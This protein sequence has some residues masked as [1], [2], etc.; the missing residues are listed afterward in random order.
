MERILD[1]QN[2][3]TIGAV[4]L[5][6]V[7][8]FIYHMS[9]NSAP[10]KSLNPDQWILFELIDKISL[11]HDVRRFRFALPSKDHVVGLPIGQHIS[12]KFTDAEG[13]AVIRS[14]TPTTNDKDDKGYFEFCVKIYSPAPPK[15]PLGG[16][17]SQH[18]DSLKIGDKVLMKG[19][20]GHV[21]YKGRGHFTIQ[22]KAS[23][24]SHTVKTIGM[25]AGGTGT[26]PF[27]CLCYSRSV[28]SNLLCQASHL[29]CS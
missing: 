6:L 27:D 7:A 5:V 8:L 4:V 3:S 13:K 2:Y 10:K 25:I 15:F 26:R 16:K 22:R 9:A 20:K 11:T 17:M 23:V 29:C 19:P 24:T 21:D 14:Y 28:A 18:L 1:A 12:L